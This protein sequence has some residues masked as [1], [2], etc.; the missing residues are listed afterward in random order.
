MV[1]AALSGAAL[2]LDDALVRSGPAD[3]IPLLRALARRLLQLAELRTRVEE[4]ASVEAAVAG[5]GRGLFW[6]DR[7]IVAR[8]LERLDA[9]TLARAIE[10]TAIVER[11]VKRGHPG[12]ALVAD[13]LLVDIVRAAARGH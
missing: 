6:K 9:A 2:A 5:A 11:Q 7:D 8:Q 3:P 13:A 12:A 1:D 10:R 4:G